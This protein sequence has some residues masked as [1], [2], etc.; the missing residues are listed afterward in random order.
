M[1]QAHTLQAAHR[2]CCS[3]QLFVPNVD[4]PLQASAKQAE[5]QAYRTSALR[6]ALEA[7]VAAATTGV[8]QLSLI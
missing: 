8:E 5:A 4:P 7:P 3:Q 2:A 1:I 6:T